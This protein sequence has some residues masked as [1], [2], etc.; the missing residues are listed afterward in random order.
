MRPS[1]YVLSA[2]TAVFV[3]GAIAPFTPRLESL[4]IE[5]AH[6]REV[7]ELPG[8]KTKVIFVT[9]RGL[10][11]S[12]VKGYKS[13]LRC[14]T[15]RLKQALDQQTELTVWHDGAT[16]YQAESSSYLI[17]DYSKGYSWDRWLSA[18]AAFAFSLP[19]WV[20]LG[21]RMNLINKPISP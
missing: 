19:I 16:V 6:V 12:C 5:K 15:T 8:N 9:P 20:F 11:L 21:R 1:L 2:I 17:I 3:F 18:F 14:P 4:T 13:T 7:N 10:N